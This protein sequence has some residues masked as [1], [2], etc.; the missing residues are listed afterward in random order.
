M[1]VLDE[2]ATLFKLFAGEVAPLIGTVAV[3]GRVFLVP[4]TE[5]EG[6]VRCVGPRYGRPSKRRFRYRPLADLV[7]Q[8]VE[9]L[10]S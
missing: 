5:F 9:F 7:R 10:H 1:V 2:G 4:A 6:H 3:Q 8:E